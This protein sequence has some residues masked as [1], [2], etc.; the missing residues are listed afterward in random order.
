MAIQ[1][2]STN[3]GAIYLGSTKIGQAYLGSVKVYGSQL[4]LPPHTI[5]CKFTSGYTP[6]KG[7]TQ[8][9]VDADEN[10]WDIY[11][12]INDWSSLLYNIPELESVIGANTTGVT[13][14][15]GM[16][17]GCS[18]L[19]N[20]PLFDTSSASYLNSMFNEC[21]SLTAVPLF[22]TSSAINMNYMFSGCTNVASGAYAL[23]QQAS[24]QSTPP[25][26]HSSCFRNCGRD[27]VT[28]AAELAMIPASWG[29][30][31]S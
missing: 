27:T 21:S 19:T 22:D 20:I 23:Y 5:R 11:K 16:F 14:M 30:K 3:F 15:S 6:T 4:V 31:A 28:G 1:L 13:S 9:L 2:G 18:S 29:G 12:S 7:D 26:A 17:T 24:S 10:I 25:S 8:T